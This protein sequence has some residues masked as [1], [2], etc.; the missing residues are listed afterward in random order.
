M[1]ICST[2]YSKCSTERDNLLFPAVLMAVNVGENHPTEDD[3]E[4]FTLSFSVNTKYH[5]AANGRGS[6][7]LHV[8]KGTTAAKRSRLNTM[9]RCDL[10]RSQ[11]SQTPS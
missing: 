5:T 4:G 2:K 1:V 7:Y 11:Q 3:D 10:S 6:I 9:A 8:E